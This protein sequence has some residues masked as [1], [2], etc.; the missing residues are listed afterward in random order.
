MTTVRMV[1]AAAFL[2]LLGGCAFV[3]ESA[4][5][6]SATVVGTDKTI[7]DHVISLASGKNCSTVRL[8]RG[9]EYCLEDEAV[10]KPDVYCYRELGGVTCYD[11]PDMRRGDH[12]RLGENDHNLVKE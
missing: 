10:P 2:W 11:K 6:N 3:P 9:L 5:V 12:G 8:E 1:V 4:V 7:A